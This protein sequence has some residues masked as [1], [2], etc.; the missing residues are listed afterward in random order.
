MVDLVLVIVVS[1]NWV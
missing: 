1:R